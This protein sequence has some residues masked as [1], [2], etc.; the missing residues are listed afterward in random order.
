MS[1][2]RLNRVVVGSCADDT[3]SRLRARALLMAGREVVFVGG[4][5]S[6][7]QLARTAEAEDAGSVVV[8][9]SAD[10]R[11]RLQSHLATRGLDHV[12]VF[13]V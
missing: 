6:V 8:D 12:G 2:E 5:Q 10:D 1:D 11:A 9:A 7:E 4:D 3:Q 13:E